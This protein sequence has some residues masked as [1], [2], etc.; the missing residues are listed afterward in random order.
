MAALLSGQPARAVAEPRYWAAIAV[1]DDA[2]I[3]VA[4]A[5]PRKE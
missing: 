4:G 3:T 1:A 5:L 2:I